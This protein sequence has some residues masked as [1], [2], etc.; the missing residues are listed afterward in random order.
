[1][2]FKERA[3]RKLQSSSHAPAS[4]SAGARR[5]RTRGARQR[6]RRR[7]QER[8][9]R[10]EGDACERSDETTAVQRQV[11]QQGLNAE[12]ANPTAR[13]PEKAAAEVAG[14]DG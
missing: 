7:G 8:Q 1:V 5:Q 11:R 10:R 14:G 2:K 9:A 6:Q 13:S 4:S 12:S 3:G